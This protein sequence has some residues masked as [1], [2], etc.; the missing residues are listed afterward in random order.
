MISGFDRYYQI[1]RCF[2]D[3]D[4]RAD[5]QPEFSQ[6][7][8]EASFVSE[9]DVMNLAEEMIVLTFKKILNVNLGSVPKIKWHLA[10][11]K[12]GC[13]KPDLRNPLIISD[14]TEIFQ[15]EDVKFDIFKKLVKSGNNVRCIVTK[16]TN[17]VNI[18]M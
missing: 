3:E 13:D 10:M 4:L 11:E 12:Y 14:L 1:A 9:E 15:R 17:Y 5:R 18:R 16:N 7:D 2:R 8:I 6:I